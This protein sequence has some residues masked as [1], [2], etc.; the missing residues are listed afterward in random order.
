MRLQLML[1]SR[2]NA[3]AKDIERGAS[4]PSSVKDPAAA[5]SHDQDSKPNRLQ[6]LVGHPL[7]R[8]EHHDV[9]GNIPFNVDP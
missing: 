3:Q 6:H 5:L 4:Q 9:T 8:I 7:R 2:R 1:C